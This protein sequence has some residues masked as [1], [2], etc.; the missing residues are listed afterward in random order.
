MVKRSEVLLWPAK[1]GLEQTRRA[2]RVS[3]EATKTLARKQI[4][5]GQTILRAVDPKEFVSYRAQE[6]MSEEGRQAE[7]DKL[8]KDL[9]EHDPKH[10]KYPELVRFS[11]P[12]ML[13]LI[14]QWKD[15]GSPISNDGIAQV[16]RF[17][18]DNNVPEE[19]ITASLQQVPREKNIEELVAEIPAQAPEQSPEIEIYSPS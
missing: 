5:F 10:P 13:K 19:F 6:E 17:F 11:V 7:I 3:I 16:E 18:R 2:G 9:R 8:G 14:D 15:D 12:L 1:F 4:G